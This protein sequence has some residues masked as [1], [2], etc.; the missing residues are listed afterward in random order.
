MGVVSGG[1]AIAFVLSRDVG[2]LKP[3]YRDVLG[4]PLLAED[5]YAATFDLGGGTS[6]RLTAVGDHVPGPHA[7][8]GWQ[9]DDL[10]TALGRLEATGTSCEIY[11]G[12]G[13]D[14]R[15]VWTSPD[16]DVRIVWFKDPEG[17]LLSMTQFN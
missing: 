1:R 6:L 17:N 11:T 9:V 5:P 13:Q 2:A 3:F 15:G 8:L 4:L 14:P 12:F 10:D 7:V 16:G